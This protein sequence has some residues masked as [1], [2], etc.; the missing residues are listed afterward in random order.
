M[1][2][3][4]DGRDQRFER[5]HEGRFNGGFTFM[6]CDRSGRVVR[7]LH[8]AALPATSGRDAAAECPRGVRCTKLFSAAFQI[9]TE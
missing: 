6:T 4:A 9:G 5:I 8:Y 7:H 3:G 1:E 2:Q